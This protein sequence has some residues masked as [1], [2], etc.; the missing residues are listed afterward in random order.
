MW[1]SFAADGASV[2]GKSSTLIESSIILFTDEPNLNINFLAGFP[3]I[4]KETL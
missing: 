2:S 1:D 4:I 3:R